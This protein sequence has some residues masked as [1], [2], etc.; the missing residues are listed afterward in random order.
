MENRNS[1]FKPVIDN[2]DFYLEFFPAMEGGK[3]LDVKEVISYL[4]HQGYFNYDMKEL[5]RA[6][7]MTE[8]VR[9]Y[10]GNSITDVVH[11]MVDIILSL[12]NMLVRCKFYPESEGGRKI[13]RENIQDELLHQ[14]IVYGI[15][16]NMIANL[17]HDRESIVPNI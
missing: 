2:K 15:D 10:I 12:D 1:Y 5:N 6:V 9:I 3:G 7:K 16:E 13:T 14:K 11:E 4:S 17:L 8:P